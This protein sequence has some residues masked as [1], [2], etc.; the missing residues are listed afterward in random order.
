MGVTLH[1]KTLDRD[2]TYI[3][4][5]HVGVILIREAIDSGMMW[6]NPTHVGVCLYLNYFT[7][8]E[9]METNLKILP[10]V[11]SRIS[12]LYIDYAKIEREDY[13]IVAIQRSE[14]LLIPI[15]TIHTL[16]L[17]P[18][19]SITH[20]AINIIASSGCHIVWCGDHGTR[21][22]SFHS[23]TRNSK[24]LLKQIEYF[25]SEEKKLYII[26]KMYAKRFKDVDVKE[27]NLKELRGL[28]G[29]Q[30]RETYKFY[31]KLYK[32]KW[33]FRNANI[34]SFEE[35]DLIN[36][37][38]T[39]LNQYLYGICHGAILSLGFSTAIGFIHTGNM[40]SFIFDV[41]DFYKE[42]YIIPL[43]FKIYHSVNQETIDSDCRK[44]MRELI[45]ENKLL[46]KIVKDI[47]ALFNTDDK[48]PELSI[49][50]I[51]D[52]FEN[53]PGSVNYGNSDLF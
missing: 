40:N 43:A 44:Y 3:N 1:H 24:N 48:E 33:K 8:G 21:F 20:G 52:P 2:V 51:W 26:R 12:F 7:K 29:T 38:I 35:Q 36:Q 27:L 19:V 22:Y 32:V 49:N 25:S 53:L 14:K 41:S 15:A 45:V 39:I 23:G 28:E 46:S 31:A 18:G 16:W 17:G 9:Y 37:I 4:P 30:V 42:K 47:L 50:E 5:T 6:I 34:T 10:R 13:A 11:D